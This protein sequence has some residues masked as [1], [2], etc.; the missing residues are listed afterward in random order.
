MGGPGSLQPPGSP[1]TPMSGPG[2]WLSPGWDLG[3]A[4]P[5]G[6][7]DPPQGAR[8]GRWQVVHPGPPSREPVAWPGDGLH[9]RHLEKR[10]APGCACEGPF[11][12]LS[13]RDP[14][15]NRV[16]IQPRIACVTRAT[17]ADAVQNHVK[18]LNWGHRVQLQDRYCCRAGPWAVV[19]VDSPGGGG[20]E[21][22]RESPVVRTSLWSSGGLH[23]PNAGARVPSLVGELDPARCS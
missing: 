6:A 13:W 11:T 17:M 1:S 4:V 5:H 8:P 10:L 15:L 20:G 21:S 7:Q 9:P 16:A 2:F 23:A 12:A 14:P 19:G 18:S 22:R 3:P